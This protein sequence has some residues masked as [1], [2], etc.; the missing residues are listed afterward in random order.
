MNKLY[1]FGRGRLAR[2]LMEQGYS[3]QE[4]PNPF[5]EGRPNWVCNLNQAGAAETIYAFLCENGYA[6]PSIITE[7][8][9]TDAEI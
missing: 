3:I 4:K 8:L 1:I 7:A 2:V 6:I 9:K 5:C